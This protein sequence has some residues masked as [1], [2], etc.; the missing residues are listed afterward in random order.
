M[1]PNLEAIKATKSTEVAQV[2][3]SLFDTEVKLEITCYR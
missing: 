1:K 2:S 3:T